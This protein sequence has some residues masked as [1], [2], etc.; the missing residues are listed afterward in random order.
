M[1][2]QRGGGLTMEP[3]AVSD[4]YARQTVLAEVGAAGQARL[5]GAHVL[6]VGAGGLG[7]PVLSYL[8]AAGVG[9][10]TVVDHD[11][12]EESNLHRQPL[13]RMSD[14]GELKVEAARRALAA[15]NPTLRVTVRAERLTAANAT[16]LIAG[17]TVVIDAADSLAVT[18]ILSDACQ[19]QALP[20]V[21]ASALGLAGYVGVFC[22]G[23]PSYRAVFPD[24]PRAA[25]SCAESGVLGS[26]VGVIGA[27]QAHL[28][29]AVLL[30]FKPSV[31]G[32]LWSLDLRTL[33][34]GGFAFADAQEPSGAPLAFI[35]PSDVLAS[36]VVIDL[37]STKEAPRSPFAAAVR[38]SVE[39]LEQGTVEVPNAPRVVLCCRSGVRAWRAARALQRR[40]CHSLA[41]LALG[42]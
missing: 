9:N 4:R 14:V 17:A 32:R 2:A 20:L 33:H 19:A 8:A 15:F 37:R 24:M 21:S 1:A 30:D 5:N 41:L 35:A 31:R 11:R 38:I 6:V 28:T 39:A 22:G 10:L 3:D 29:L 26:V 23:T 7:C 12:V 36:D 18:Y 27:L 25:G 16:S 40:G 34:L 42:E 13:Y